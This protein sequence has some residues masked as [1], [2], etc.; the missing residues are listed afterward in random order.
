MKEKKFDSFLS[1]NR[2]D[3]EKDPQFGNKEIGKLN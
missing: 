1:Q 2:F 3:K